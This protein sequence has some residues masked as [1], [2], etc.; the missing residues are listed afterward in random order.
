METPS[1]LL[2][3]PHVG[4]LAGCRACELRTVTAQGPTASRESCF[5][6]KPGN[7]SNGSNGTNETNCSSAPPS[8]EFRMVLNA[9]S[10]TDNATA[11][12]T[13]NYSGPPLCPEA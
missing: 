1:C 12:N 6:S 3:S 11:V 7:V 13:A 8:L 9:R 10:G 5:N 2:Q 4:P